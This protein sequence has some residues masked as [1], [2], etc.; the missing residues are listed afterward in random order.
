[1][2][3]MTPEKELQTKK[4]EMAKILIKI[5]ALKFGVFKLTSG[6][7]SPY[8]IDL[9]IVPS[10]PDAFKQIIDFYTE[11]ITQQIGTDKFD[12]IAGVPIAG[13]P[14]ASQI[15]YNLKKPFLYVRKGIR[16]HGRKRR[17]EG[18]LVS[19]DRVLIIDDLVTTGLNMRKAADAIRAEGGVVTDAVAF[20]DR[21]EG[22][23][24]KLTKDGLKLN[25]LMKISEVAKILFETDAIDEE[26]YKTIMKQIKKEKPLQS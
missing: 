24:T 10:F 2:N 3:I 15:A 19:G 11:Q 25:A 20:L 9:R 8:Y 22:G 5:D 17:V 12:R 1:M 6:K 4:A 16:R 13:I 21:E 7:S 14:F 18:I 26:S 23:K